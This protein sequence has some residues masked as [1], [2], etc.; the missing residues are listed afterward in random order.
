MSVLGKQVGKCD[1]LTDTGPTEPQTGWQAAE[2]EAAA[3]RSTSLCAEMYSQPGSFTGWPPCR[4]AEGFLWELCR[5]LGKGGRGKSVSTPLLQLPLQQTLGCEVN[6]NQR[7][8]NN[9]RQ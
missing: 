6:L 3:T 9:Y 4:R 2:A 1:Q 7:A 8:P 5:A